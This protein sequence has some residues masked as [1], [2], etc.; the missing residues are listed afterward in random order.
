[1]LTKIHQ[2][3]FWW[4]NQNQTFEQEVGGGYLWSPKRNSNGVRNRFYENMREVAPG[5]IIFSFFK[6]RIPAI[7]VAVS[8]AYECPKPSEFGG[9]GPNWSRIGWKVETCFTRLDYL[10]RPKEHIDVLRPLLPERY[11]PLQAN[12]NGLQQVYLAEVSQSF[13]EVLAG[14][15]GQEYQVILGTTRLPNALEIEHLQ[16]RGLDEWEDHIE[17]E[18]SSSGAIPETQRIALVKARRGQGTYRK[19]LLRIEKQCRITKVDN[20]IHLVGS[21]I[22]PWRDCSNEE[23]LDG[24]NGLLLTPSIDHMFDRGFISFNGSGELLVSPRADYVSLSRMG[25]PVKE[26]INVGE[27][28]SEQRSY[29]E[30]HRDQVLLQTS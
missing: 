2:R 15:I 7:G 20:P 18:I 12:G 29:L 27:F 13:A 19:N 24:E 8:Y 28:T 26:H 23:R 5:D 1:M 14:L 25:L 11:S 4:V 6:T 16:R 9:A 10:V 22:K 30:F 17:E 3:R 21:H